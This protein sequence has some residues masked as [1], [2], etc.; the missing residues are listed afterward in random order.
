MPIFKRF[1]KDCLTILTGCNS[2]TD[3]DDAF[4]ASVFLR[5]VHL[6]QLEIHLHGRI[7]D[8]LLV[9]AQIL[10]AVSEITRSDVHQ[11]KYDLM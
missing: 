10:E 7:Q 2:A 1:G 6:L 8:A 3:A 5:L 11:G 4:I 9:L